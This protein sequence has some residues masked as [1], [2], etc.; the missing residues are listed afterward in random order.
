[1]YLILQII[2][3][4]TNSDKDHLKIHMSLSA[5]KVIVYS[6]GVT[7]TDKNMIITCL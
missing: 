5:R 1:M 3:S 7:E 2:T 6:K 4:I